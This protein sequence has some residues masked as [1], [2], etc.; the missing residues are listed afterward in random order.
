[1][2][3]MKG[4]NKFLRNK[5]TVTILGVLAC[6]AILFVGYNIRINQKTALVTVYY[7]NQTIQPKTKITE[8]MI[9]RT[10]VP[11]SF[12]L[13]DY[14]KSYENIIGKYSNYNTMIAKGSLFYNDLLV[15]EAN[16]PDA[17][18]YDINEGERVISFPVNTVST[19]GNS[20]MPGNIVDIYV[21]LIDNSG[22]VVYGEFFE[23]IETL[24]VK[25]SSGKNVF[26][27]TEEERTPAF[28]YFS[29]PEAKYLLFTSLN[30]IKEYDG[31]SRIEIVIVPNTAKFDAQ[32]PL[33]TEVTSDYLYKYVLDRIS[34]IDD[35]KELYEE[36]LNEME[37]QELEK[38]QNNQ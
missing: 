17:I 33:A 11:Q 19:Y 38:K 36:L 22:K 18:F 34:Q 4:L 14:Y 20:I 3:K 9:S 8:D 5:N 2:N 35:Q 15:E 32:D 16:L 24:A 12:I 29:L 6:I 25:D 23:N 28:L 26:E 27:N 37:Q 21:K 31:A 10:Q 30:Y 1:M 13:G 7:A